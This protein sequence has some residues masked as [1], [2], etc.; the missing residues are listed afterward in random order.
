VAGGIRTRRG[1]GRCTESAH[2]E[3]EPD[4]VRGDKNTVSGT[5]REVVDVDSFVIRAG[6]RDNIRER[7]RL[8]FFV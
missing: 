2:P 6:N 3:S 7:R 5:V 1:G 4:I 8:D